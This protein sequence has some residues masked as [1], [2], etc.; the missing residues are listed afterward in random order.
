MTLCKKKVATFD[1]FVQIILS[2]SLY[3]FTVKQ[4]KIKAKIRLVFFM[5]VKLINYKG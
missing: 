4:A 1:D 5:N 2:F 3:V